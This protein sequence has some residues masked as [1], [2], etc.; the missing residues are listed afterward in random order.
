[1]AKGERNMLITTMMAKRKGLNAVRRLYTD[2]VVVDWTLRRHEDCSP[3]CQQKK[4]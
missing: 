3:E 1:M 4:G 2:L